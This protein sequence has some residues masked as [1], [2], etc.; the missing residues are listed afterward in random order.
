M[1]IFDVKLSELTFVATYLRA[2]LAV[3]LCAH[4]REEGF[5]LFFR[6]LQCAFLDARVGV[7]FLK[8]YFE[9]RIYALQGYAEVGLA[10]LELFLFLC[11]LGLHAF[12]A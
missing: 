5:F 9:L 12:K 10:C 8:Y 6:E 2:C 7:S 1:V 11:D 4:F 3:D